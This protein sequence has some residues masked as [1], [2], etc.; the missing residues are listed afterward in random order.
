M[1][2]ARSIKD[3]AIGSPFLLLQFGL[4]GYM[5]YFAYLEAYAR[6]GVPH[7]EGGVG[8]HPAIATAYAVWLTYVFLMAMAS[9]IK[10]FIT[11]PGKVTAALV[12]K[13]K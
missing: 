13:L 1:S 12:D 4:T 6:I 7:H 5:S 10:T 9:F 3:I 8:G 11:P 2:E